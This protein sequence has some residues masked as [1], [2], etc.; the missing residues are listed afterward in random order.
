MYLRPLV[1]GRDDTRARGKRR[2]TG[3][4]D[5]DDD[6]ERRGCAAEILVWASAIKSMRRCV[7]ICS[8]LANTPVECQRGD[9][10]ERISRSAERGGRVGGE[11]KK[12]PPRSDLG[13]SR[14]DEGWQ[15]LTS[16]FGGRSAVP[17]AESI[18]GC[19]RL[20]SI[21]S[22]KG[23][24][25]GSDRIAVGFRDGRGVSSY[26]TASSRLSR[27]WPIRS[28][29]TMNGGNDWARF[30][31]SNIRARAARGK[32]S[33]LMPASALRFERAFFYFSHDDR[34]RASPLLPRRVSRVRETQRG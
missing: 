24:G 32:G 9:Y 17:L 1:Y 27:L 29:V 4:D 21:G 11:G 25:Q 5:D 22:V 18:P 14:Q 31:C 7:G 3:D 19:D 20:R 23:I 33:R 28:S 15:P 6:D 16:F 13:K 2:R 8:R 26:R 12:L 10:L 30:D 34:A